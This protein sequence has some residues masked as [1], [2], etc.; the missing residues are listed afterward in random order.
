M[1]E[2]NNLGK[3]S[4]SLTCTEYSSEEKGILDSPQVVYPP[5]ILRL[6]LP[7]ASLDKKEAFFK[8]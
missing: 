4:S 5:K 2:S 6:A 8:S 7:E 1:I 3:E